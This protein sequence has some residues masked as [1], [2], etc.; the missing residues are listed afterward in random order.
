MTGFEVKVV[1]DMDSFQFKQ[2]LDIVLVTEHNA[3]PLEKI[4]QQQGYHWY[5]G[6]RLIAGKSMFQVGQALFV[7]D[8]KNVAHATAKYAASQAKAHAQRN[9]TKLYL[10]SDYIFVET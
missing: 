3:K 10:A 2:D 6:H 9:P 7:Y 1:T 8:D 5:G 4:F